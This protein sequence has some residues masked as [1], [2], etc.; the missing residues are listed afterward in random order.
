MDP[1][2]TPIFIALIGTWEIGLTGI[3]ISS[4][5]ANITGGMLLVGVMALLA[6]KPPKPDDGKFVVQNSTPA[7]VFAYGKVRMAGS[8]ALLE[9]HGGILYHVA[10]I[11]AHKCNAVTGYYLHDDSV[12]VVDDHVVA[13]ADKRYLNNCVSL[14]YRLGEDTETPYSRAV[15]ALSS[16]GLWT[17]DYRGD[18]ITSLLMTCRAPKAAQLG[19]YYPL[20]RPQPSL[21]LESAIIYD[22]RDDTWRYSDNTALEIIH[23][24][25]FS[26]FGPQ[27]EYDKTILPVVDAWIEAAN[28]CDELVNLRAGGSE[29]RYRSGGFDTTEHDTRTVLNELLISCD[30]WLS[31]RGDGTCTLVVGKYYPPTQTITDDDIIGWTIQSDVPDEYAVNEIAATFC[32][33]DA[34]YNMTAV[35]TW[36]YTEDQIARGSKRSSRM[37]LNWVQSF[38]QARRLGKREL[39]RQKE[40]VRGQLILNLGGMG[41]IASRFVNVSSKIVPFLNG[42][43]IE[44][45]KAVVSLQTASITLDYIGSGA[46]IDDWNPATDEGTP[47]PVPIVA[48]T[49]LIPTPVNVTVTAEVIDGIVYADIQ[50]DTPDYADLA[51]VVRWRYSNIAGSPGS[52]T[53]VAYDEPPDPVAGRITLNVS[54]LPQSTNVDIELCSVSSRGSRSVFTNPITI[55]TVPTVAAPGTPTNGSA[56]G[57]V[58]SAT[59]SW[60]NPNS[61]T[62]NHTV[63]FRGPVGDPFSL[64]DP[65]SGSIYGAANQAMAYT[66]IVSSGDYS[67]W[68]V[69]YSSSSA[70]STPAGPFDATVT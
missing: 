26:E 42:K 40:T 41:K 55:S 61:A 49:K 43:V 11:C 44:N 20:G 3:T 36:E 24:L 9:E 12:E 14:E 28:V 58:G 65:V 18:G 62:F 47:P 48:A 32:F 33:P 66:D 1:I 39:S 60:Y 27:R 19:K 21:E 59:V 2:L 4:V 57:G 23:F 7:R 45:R 51:Y 54:P 8:I 25:C 68:V 70:A 69:A 17:N 15:T 63:V 29:K 30:G 31:E 53:E 35:D 56:T 50:F 52:W 6:P 5:L 67:Y 46:Y 22:P 34:G 38:S 64:S 10:A 13:L 16:I 37:E